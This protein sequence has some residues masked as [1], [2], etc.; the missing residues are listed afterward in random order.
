MFMLRR[1]KC[2]T[3]RAWSVFEAQLIVSVAVADAELPA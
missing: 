1:L 3:T 2:K